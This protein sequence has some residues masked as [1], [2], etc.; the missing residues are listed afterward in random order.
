MQHD[1]P[2][3]LTGRAGQCVEHRDNAILAVHLPADRQ[4]A[5]A[6]SFPATDRVRGIQKL[7]QKAEICE[8]G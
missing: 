3:A 6:A 5:V 8:I 4:I 7:F 2:S 1:P